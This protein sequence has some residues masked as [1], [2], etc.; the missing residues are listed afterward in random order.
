MNTI[1]GKVLHQTKNVGLQDLIVLLYDIDYFLANNNDP[2]HVD[3][4]NSAN[5]FLDALLPTG[6]GHPMI[7]FARR[8]IYTLYTTRDENEDPVW[9]IMSPVGGRLGSTLTGSD[10]NFSI[11]FDDIAFQ[12]NDQEQRPDALLLVLAPDQALNLTLGESTTSF[13]GTPEYQRILHMSFFPLRNMAREESVIIKIDEAQLRRFNLDE[14]IVPGA[15]PEHINAYLNTADTFQSGLI[16]AL[17]DR[18]RRNVTIQQDRQAKAKKFALN[19]SALPKAVRRSGYFLH[20]SEV[21]T[22]R[23]RNLQARISRDGVDQ[24]ALQTLN[25]PPRIPQAYLSIDENWLSRLLPNGNSTEVLEALSAGS[26]IEVEVDYAA[27]CAMLYTKNGGAELTRNGDSLTQ[28]TERDEVLERIRALRTVT[29]DPDPDDNP[30][31]DDPDT[32]AS[33]L[34]AEDQI[35]AL[36]LEQVMRL[37]STNMEGGNTEEESMADQRKRISISLQEL[38]PPVSPADATAYHDYTS[39]QI[40]FP[41]IWTEAFDG[42]VEELVGALRITYEEAFEAYREGDGDVLDRLSEFSEEEIYDLKEYTQLLGQLTGDISSFEKSPTPELVKK[43]WTTQVSG[44]G[45]RTYVQAGF[46]MEER[47]NQLSMGQQA[48]LIEMA[49]TFNRLLSSVNRPPINSMHGAQQF[50]Q[51]QFSKDQEAEKVGELTKL[52]KEVSNQ[53]TQ[54]NRAETLAQLEELRSRALSIAQ[55]PGG[56]GTRAQRL[57]AELADRLKAPHSFQVFAENAYNFG[58]LTTHRQKW[59]PGEYQTGNLVSTITLAP[60]E[61]RQY[62]KKET[63][64]RTRNRKEAEKNA[65]TLNDERVYSNKATEDIANKASTNTNFAQSVSG[66]TSGQLG[67]FSINAQSSTEFGRDQAA[68]SER[69]K[70]SIRESTRK[71]A[72][73]YRN[74]RSLEITTEAISEQE[75][76]F[77]SEIS[78]PNNEITVT[79]LFYELER[80]YKVTE[81]LHKVSPVILVA[82]NVPAP[83]EIDEDWILTHEWILRRVILDR[84]F[85]SSLDFIAEGLISDEVSLEV[86]REN[87]ETQ[88][89]LVEDL[90]TTVSSLNQLQ[91]SLRN[92]LIQTSAREKLAETYAKRAKKSRRRRIARRLFDPINVR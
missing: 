8:V 35:K 21:D 58:I 23:L 48:E 24:I 60:G 28:R 64:K 29:P 41:N 4:N 67:V 20:R 73:E 22:D 7:Q 75:S 15:S 31:D 37:S 84:S 86:L 74:E 57:M 26:S 79:Y 89:V 27:F 45:I 25:N 71:A 72:Q 19:I 1:S 39:L 52:L 9:R 2:T 38:T 12:G 32:P 70:Q 92:T 46:D 56:K 42:N 33:D 51:D 87:Y 55:N 36:V 91:E 11:R 85:L 13:I 63:L 6:E 3:P 80:Q 77:T 30:P 61:K 81:H 44:V 50:L 40:A 10:G 66:S 53:S 82:Q 65:S 78:N 47:W 14:N 83:H 62:V 18:A 5:P 88:K 59:V 16:N 68:E 17:R 69:S 49:E 34:N 54:D 76:S 43:I 90:S